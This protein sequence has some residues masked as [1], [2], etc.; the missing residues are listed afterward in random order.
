MTDLP[1]VTVVIP[2]WNEGRFIAEFLDSLFAQTYPA[3]RLEIL[4]VDGMSEDDTRD[5]LRR[6][7]AAHPALRMLDNPGHRKPDGLNLAIRQARGEI[8]VRMDVHA[9]YEPD[10]LRK[11][12]LALLAHPEADNVGGVLKSLPRDDTLLGRALALSIMH[13]LA[14]GNAKHR[15]G[16]SEPQW[17]DTVFGG[18]WRREVFDRIGYF[19]EKLTRAQDREFNQRL[20]ASGGKIL[21]IPD[22]VCTY[23]ARSSLRDYG[24]WI[25]E[26]G[27]WPFRASRL[28]GRWIGGW[29]NFVPLAFVAGSA[30]GL[31]LSPRSVVV[32]RLTGAGLLTYAGAVLGAS[33]HLAWR[34]R[35]PGLLV[36]MPVAFVVTHT[37]YGAGSV[38][39]I[40]APLPAAEPEDAPLQEGDVRFT[41][42]P[43]TRLQIATV[44]RMHRDGVREGFLSTLGEP[45]LRLLYR[46]VATSRH[47]KMF[48]AL[49]PGGETIGY[50][51]GCRDTSALYRE[52]ALRRWPS[53]VRV[54]LPR[55]LSPARLR[56]AVET[57]RY[58]SAA[59]AEL[60]R[61]EVINVVV[62]PA[63][64]GRGVAEQ[65]LARLMEWFAEQGETAVKAVSGDQLTRAHRFYEKS[66]ARLEGHTS[67][68]RGVGS[69]VYVYS[70]D[71]P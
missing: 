28:V 42:G 67:V 20:R 7:A 14:A 30:A 62:Q 25:F 54:L 49:A 12:V 51:A 10:Y 66:G 16:V 11:C 15:V 40:A 61:A 18:C 64:R 71:R 55:L 23:Y 22:I 41:D 29:R 1:L 13:P 50:I 57:L 70:V 60:P 34:R 68:H 39:G 8:V 36:A 31:A 33:A 45:A 59:P 32:R 46:H 44:A 48:V 63:W 35:D 5:I 27:Y 47:C 65:L 69:R 52:F 37:V 38:W 24:S 26:A 21:L 4:L 43:L 56:R 17:I 2:C 3:D 6:Y 58:P 19:D 53:A 9:F